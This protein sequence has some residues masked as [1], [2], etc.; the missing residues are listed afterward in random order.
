MDIEAVFTTVAVVF[1]VIG[2]L[3]MCA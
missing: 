2:A 3:A 1:E